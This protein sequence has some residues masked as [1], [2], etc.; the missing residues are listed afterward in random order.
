VQARIELLPRQQFVRTFHQAALDYSRTPWVQVA[1]FFGSIMFQS[2]QVPILIF[3]RKN[4]L[5]VFVHAEG[6]WKKLNETESKELDPSVIIDLA[7][8]ATNSKAEIR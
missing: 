8:V 5:Q 1:N 4:D 6:N 2:N 3:C 7:K